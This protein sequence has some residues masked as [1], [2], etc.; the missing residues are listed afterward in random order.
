V[1][2]EE[3]IDGEELLK[4]IAHWVYRDF[5]GTARHI[6]AMDK[7][8]EYND[9]IQDIYVYIKNRESEIPISKIRNYTGGFLSNKVKYLKNQDKIKKENFYSE[10]LNFNK[11]IQQENLFYGEVKSFD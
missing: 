2:Y 6:L 11:K 4:F 9:L 5:R 8:L 3:V 10:D 7:S 1:N